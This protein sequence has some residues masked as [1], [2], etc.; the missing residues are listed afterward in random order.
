[1]WFWNKKLKACG[2]LDTVGRSI[3]QSDERQPTNVWGNACLLKTFPPSWFRLQ[4][5]QTRRVPEVK[6]PIT[7]RD[8]LITG[9]WTVTDSPAPVQAGRILIVLALIRN[10]VGLRVITAI[11]LH[12][13]H[14]SFGGY[15]SCINS[16]NFCIALLVRM[17]SSLHK[18]WSFLSVAIMTVL[19]VAKDAKLW[20]CA[21]RHVFGGRPISFS[22]L[23][24][25][26]HSSSLAL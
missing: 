14:M 9:L 22:F 16:F 7:I 3:V 11:A 12:I 1:M 21:Y 25:Y 15:C 13:D 23:S 20:K 10:Q 4:P 6:C 2:C 5:P 17:S 24:Q 26:R 18:F 19:L 8:H